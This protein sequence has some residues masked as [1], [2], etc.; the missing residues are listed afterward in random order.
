[1]VDFM[2]WI[3]GNIHRHHPQIMQAARHQLQ[4]W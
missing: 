4:G 2:A 1:M 3:T